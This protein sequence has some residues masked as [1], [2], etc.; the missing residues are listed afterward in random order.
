[1]IWLWLR[2]LLSRI[3]GRLLGAIMGVALTVAL[4]AALGAFLIASS[5]SMTRR[6]SDALPVDWQIELVPGTDTDAVKAAI[7]QAAATSRVQLAGYAD[8]E[9]FT[10]ST[11]GTV[12]TTGAGKVVGLDS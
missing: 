12:Q 7:G 11:V 3:P 5:T 9:A 4:I 1:M 8:V 2:G 10:A 6:A